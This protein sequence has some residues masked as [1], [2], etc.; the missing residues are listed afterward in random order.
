MEDIVNLIVP[1]DIDAAIVAAYPELQHLLDLRHGGWRFLPIEPGRSQIDGF[2][3]W[4]AG[5]TDAIR[6]KDSGD[7]L[8]L[9]LDGE[10]AI[11]WEYAGALAE[12][13]QELLLLPQPSS[14]LAPRLA[15]GKGPKIG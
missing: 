3:K 13:V 1:G 12:V 15:R 11:T 14:R 9:R 5:W 4:P 7:A 6:I 8:G 10:H 2:R